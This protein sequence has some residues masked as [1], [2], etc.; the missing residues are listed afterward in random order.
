[1]FNSLLKRQFAYKKP[2]TP[3]K[4]WRIFKGDT[5]QINAGR[6]KGK[7]G[8]VLKVYRKSNKILVDGINIKMKRVKGDDDGEGIGG[9]RPI[10]H[11]IHVSNANLVDPSSGI[12]TRVAIGYLEDGTKVRVAKRS[13]AIIERPSTEEFSYENRHKNKIDG[14]GDTAPDRVL[15]VTYKGEDFDRIRDDFLAEIAEKDAVEDLLVFDK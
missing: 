14:Q 5:V 1:M 12:G 13:G 15:E 3:F 11:P 2:Q 7:I 4:F 9:I 8:E 10:L 6:D